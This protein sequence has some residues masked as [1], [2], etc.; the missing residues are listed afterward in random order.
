MTNLL[1]SLP[2]E[3]INLIYEYDDTYHDRSDLFG[4]MKNRIVLKNKYDKKYIIIDFQSKMISINNPNMYKP[5]FFIPLCY[6]S[7]KHIMKMIHNKI[8]KLIFPM[9]EGLIKIFFIE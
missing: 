1:Y 5:L 4:Q 6:W 7:K 3:L 9:D 2:N 8:F